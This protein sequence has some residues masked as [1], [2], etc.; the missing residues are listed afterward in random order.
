MPRATYWSASVRESSSF[1][2][3]ELPH[4]FPLSVCSRPPCARPTRPEPAGQGG[5]FLG[6]EATDLN[7]GFS[8]LPAARAIW[9]CFG[10]CGPTRKVWLRPAHAP[11]FPMR[12]CRRRPT[13][14]VWSSTDRSKIRSSTM[15]K[16]ATRPQRTMSER[17]CTA[18]GRSSRFGRV[19]RSHLE[20]FFT[21]ANEEGL[22][23]GPTS[24]AHQ[25]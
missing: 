1:S 13:A 8:G 6:D 17:I 4:D 16:S 9:T 3:P 10:T 19:R 11:G 23:T 2:V 18:R 5:S 12:T 24:F 20:S 7:C 25:C 21:G 22:A 14:L 15:M